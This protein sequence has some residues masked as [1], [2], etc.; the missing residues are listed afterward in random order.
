MERRLQ[1]TQVCDHRNSTVQNRL[2]LNIHNSNI[3]MVFYSADEAESSSLESG[4]LNL[5]FMEEEKEAEA[6]DELKEVLV[7]GE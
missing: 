5:L 6:K 3:F 2:C 1:V 4:V 7:Q